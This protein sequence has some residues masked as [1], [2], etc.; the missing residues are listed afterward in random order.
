MVKRNFD[1][2]KLMEL[3]IEVMRKSVDEPRQDEKANP[4]VGVVLYKPDGTI[5]T[6]CRGELRNGDHAEYTLL[7]RKN[8]SAKLDGSVL[9]A[10]LE[11]CAPG[12]RDETKLSCAERIVLAR[13]A[14]V[15]IGIE[16][17]DPTVDRKGIKFLQDN[18]IKVD[19]FDRNLQEVIREE[20]KQFLAQAL[21]RAEA[22]E[23][24]KEAKTV[25]LSFLE[26]PIAAVAMGDFSSVAL[27]RYRNI[28]RIGDAIESTA[29]KRRFIQQGLLKEK[30][31][32]I[33]PTGSGILLFGKAPREVM[34]QAGLLGTI[35]YSDGTE[36]TRDFDGS[37]VLIPKLVEQWLQNKLPSSLDRSRMQRRKAP[38][39][40]FELVREAVVNALI[41]RDYEIAGAK[42]QLVVTP[43]TIVVRSPG[44]PLLPV[45]LEKLQNFSAPMLSRNPE[46]HYVFARMKLAEER[47]LGMKTFRTIPEEHGFPLPKYAFD[48]PYL[49]LTLYRNQEGAVSAL[50]PEAIKALNKDEREG[51]EFLASKITATKT[52]YAKHLGFDDRKAQRHLKKFVKLRLLRRVGAGPS[53]SYEVVR[54]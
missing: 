44:S 35:H 46:L 19:L 45:T 18:G 27:K 24:P 13:I 22:A 36:D 16:D 42:C 39:L 33:V 37:M 38:T 3:A 9:F 23:E 29:F 2:R 14:K 54:S 15:W 6:A 11:P 8:L 1:A 5:E 51:W 10:T 52:E 47:G 28:T 32:N 30:N 43:D 25:T 40:P 53:T 26:H 50:A 7:E 48:D 41:H 34:P 31:N 17:P 49:E 4:R 20:N 21:E 12:S